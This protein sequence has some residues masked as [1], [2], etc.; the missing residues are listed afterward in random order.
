MSGLRVEGFVEEVWEESILPV[1]ERYIRIPNKSPLF[2]PDWRRHGFMDAAV[3]EVAA[4]CRS[5]A[6]PGLVV[7]VIEDPELTPLLYLEVP[8]HPEAA[9]DTVLLYGHLDKQPRL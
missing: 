7:E 5:R 3:A 4:W 9:D 8:G 2:D 1:L 6:I